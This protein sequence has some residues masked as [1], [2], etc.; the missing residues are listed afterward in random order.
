VA[1]FN[2]YTASDGLVYI[3][4]SNTRRFDLLCAAL[5][6]AELA[7]DPRFR[8]NEGRMQVWRLGLV[9]S[10]AQG[11]ARGGSHPTPLR[12]CSFAHA[13]LLAVVCHSTRACSSLPLRLQKFD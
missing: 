8:T 11:S 5:R 6:D 2:G 7:T 9:R 1:P 10:G 4:V 3:A 12:A 13:L